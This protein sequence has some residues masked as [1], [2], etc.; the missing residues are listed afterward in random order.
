MHS[1]SDFFGRIGE[2]EFALIVENV[3]S[4]ECLIILAKK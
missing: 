4:N 3:S 1:K 2:D